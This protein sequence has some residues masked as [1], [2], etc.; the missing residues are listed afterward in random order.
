MLDL[1]YSLGNQS[2]RLASDVPLAEHIR[3]VA[4]S[5]FKLVGIDDWYLDQWERGDQDLAS[6]RRLLDAQG[7]RCSD[8]GPLRVADERSTLE[9]MHRLAHAG[10]VLEARW[11]P[12]VVNADGPERGALLARC[13]AIAVEAGVGLAVEFIPWTALPS[14]EAARRLIR[15][16][17]DP[18]VRI[19]LD[20]FQLDRS[21][22]TWAEAEALDPEEIGFIQLCDALGNSADLRFDS[23]HRRALPGAGELDLTPLKRLL[24]RAAWDGIVS[25]EVLS[26]ELRAQDPRAVAA[27]AFR[28]ARACLGA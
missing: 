22:S 10:R 13:S 26:A 11:I 20:V 5:G 28:A 6:L 17:D 23:S 1:S 4:P 7:L 12:V 21:S 9:A 2:P 18:S 25:L 15:E 24:A 14:L 27:E 16:V 8:V 3:A 19:L